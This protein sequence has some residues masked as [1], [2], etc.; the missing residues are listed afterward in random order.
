[1]C[2]PP[3]C[4]C[5]ARGESN[6]IRVILSHFGMIRRRDSGGGGAARGEAGRAP[7]AA[8]A[9][10]RGGAA[11]PLRATVSQ[12][13]AGLAPA[14]V[15]TSTARRSLST[16]PP[17]AEKL[18]TVR[19]ASAA[20]S[21]CSPVSPPS[22][23]VCCT[24]DGTPELPAA[25]PHRFEMYATC[26]L[27]QS[28]ALCDTPRCS[29]SHRPSV[30]S[31]RF[32]LSRL[33]SGEPIRSWTVSWATLERCCSTSPAAEATGA[34]R[35]ARCREDDNIHIHNQQRGRQP[36][37][38][39]AAATQQPAASQTVACAQHARSVMQPHRLSGECI[40]YLSMSA[41]MRTANG[42]GHSDCA[43]TVGGPAYGGS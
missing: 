23:A 17:R 22:R 10:G 9:R 43:R 24:R 39:V 32:D 6:R 12:T 2:L 20:R 21:P 38:S 7:I 15:G 14:A 3:A 41:M 35:R 5:S 33:L 25:L 29:P 31:G 11:L 28:S 36:G 19:R 26:R 1:V 30:C 16:S 34:A 4:P 37:D 13:L 27:Q 42:Q 18:N 8:A 40:T